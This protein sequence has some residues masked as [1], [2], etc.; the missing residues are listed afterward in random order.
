MLAIVLVTILSSAARS[1]PRVVLDPALRADRAY[2]F[3]AGEVAKAC[4]GTV[5]YDA[6][7]SN[8]DIAAGH[9]S[10]AVR[11]V[12]PHGAG[13]AL[14]AEGFAIRRLGRVVAV[15][16]SDDRGDLYGMLW[17]AERLRLDPTHLAHPEC[18]REPALTI[19]EITDGHDYLRPPVRGYEGWLQECL[20]LGI[21]T[22]Q[23][24]GTT[25]AEADLGKAYRMRY[26][27]GTSPFSNLPVDDLIARHG[28]EVSEFPGQL[29]PLKPLVWE[30]H[31]KQ[32]RAMLDQ[33]PQIDFV[34]ASMGDLPE[35]FHVYDCHGPECAKAGRA[36]GL[37]R[38]CQA[39]W[40]V[41]VGERA[42]TFFISSWGNPPERYPL[43][44]P[45]DYRRIMESLPER[46][47]VSTVNNT[48]HDFHLSS[49]TNPLIGAS[50]RPLDLYFEVTAEYA[51]AGFLPVYTGPQIQQRTAVAVRAGNAVGITGRLWEGVGLWTRDVLWTRANLYAAFRAGWEPDGDPEAWVR[52]WAALTFGPDGASGLAAALMASQEIARRTF[53]V[54][55]FSG[56]KGPAYAITRRNVITDGTHYVR[57]AKHPHLTAYRRCAMPQR[58]QRSL[59]TLDGAE[60][61]RDRM[62][63]RW[64]SARPR[65][66]DR[67][68]A[69][70]CDRDF[71]HFA[72]VVAV[73]VPYQRALL[74]WCHTQDAGISVAER[75]RS[76]R[77]SVRWARR[78]RSAWTRY[79]SA[80]D[81]H[82]DAGMTEMLATY[83]RDCAALS[84]RTPVVVARPAGLA[85]IVVSVLNNA[86]PGGLQA[87]V[88]PTLPAGWGGDRERAA[89]VRFGD[90]VA[91]TLRVAPPHGCAIG[92]FAMPIA[93]VDRQG[94]TLERIPARVKVMSDG[95]GAPLAGSRPTVLCSRT[96]RAPHMDG[97]IEPGEWPDGGTGWGRAPVRADASAGGNTYAVT[98]RYA[99]D[100][101]CLFVAFEVADDVA[102]TQGVRDTIYRGDR[103]HLVLD[104]DGDRRDDYEIAFVRC[105]DGRLVAWPL[106]VDGVFTSSQLAYRSQ[107]ERAA[108]GLTAAAG[109][110]PEGPGRTIE[111]C[112]PWAWLGSYRP[113]EGAV[114]GVAFRGGDMDGPGGLRAAVQW[115]ER[116]QLPDGPYLH[117]G[118][119]DKPTPFADMVFGS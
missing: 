30:E 114:V 17:L 99:W 57:W 82:R 31:R 73:L 40:D 98:A 66:T 88:R 108:A 110:N 50:R 24:A 79:R 18:I 72:A 84:A 4:G 116:A 112:I 75:S 13:R 70:A 85:T 20:K 68:L 74:H 25:A 9:A 32:L 52:D 58:L 7:A 95:P 69:A 96:A 54:P 71:R 38:A 45:E 93:L 28:S 59:A 41:V 97:R 14:R 102:T 46:G 67:G 43:N 101:R 29:C 64:A 94:R 113:A 22:I 111:A 90:R 56:E 23:H 62:M 86:W 39:T 89:D 42:K 5:V 19:R 63:A 78:T 15:I 105:A 65:M 33:Y 36:E 12:A 47:I 48:Q 91:V 60:R 92:D 87:R 10:P 103:E 37:L 53:W 106:T 104:L 107:V 8:G 81:L 6:R 1:G 34:R 55:G 119:V 109:T 44:I 61:L 118:R 27:G 83:E 49:P 76:A 51:G 21:N 117:W 11:S 77:E 115:P 35:D 3:A 80:F 100:A 26:M 16:G 2:A